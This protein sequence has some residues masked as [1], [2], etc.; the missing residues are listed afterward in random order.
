MGISTLDWPPRS[1][2][3]NPIEH[4]WAYS[5]KKYSSRNIS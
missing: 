1:P 5:A 3:I 2:D 4:V